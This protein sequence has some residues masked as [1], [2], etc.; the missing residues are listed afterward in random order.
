MKRSTILAGI[1]LGIIMITN[2][3]GTKAPRDERNLI[4]QKNLAEEIDAYYHDKHINTSSKVIWQVIDE[5]QRTLPVYFKNNEF[6]LEHVLAI[7]AV[8]SDFYPNAIG[9][10]GES[11]IFQILH[12]K[13]VMNG[14]GRPGQDPMDVR[15]N[16]QMAILV[17]N[18]KLRAYGTQT[19]AIIAYNGT[20]KRS[21]GSWDDKYLL[22]FRKKHAIILKMIQRAKESS[23][24]T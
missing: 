16:T 7:A 1:F 20:V 9:A 4:F 8:E 19:R 5:A 13:K 23:N 24:L 15:N 18:N 17:L 12:A 3:N 22:R 6:S 10:A 11:G 21:D 2:S 14:I